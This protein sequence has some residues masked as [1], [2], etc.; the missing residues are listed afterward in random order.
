MELSHKTTTVGLAAYLTLTND[1]LL[2]IVQQRENRL[3]L[4][5]IPKEPAKFKKELDLK[6][7][8]PEDN[9]AAEQYT[10]KI[11]TGVKH[12][13]LQQ[14]QTRWEKKAM[15]GRYPAWIKEADVD[16]KTTNQWLKSYGLKAKTE[17]T[18][19]SN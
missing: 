14:M 3:K 18:I 11:K 2:R 1:S 12:L 16:M 10:K 19:T 6:E 8:Q 5:S 7:L 17:G 9:E 4:Y 15:H 13:G